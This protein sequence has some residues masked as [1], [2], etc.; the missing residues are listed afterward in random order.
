M[1]KDDFSALA[2]K[3][4]YEEEVLKHIA[5]NHYDYYQPFHLI[6]TKNG[7]T[8]TRHIDNPGKKTA[9]GQLQKKLNKRLLLP[10]VNRLPPEMVGSIKG[11]NLFS[12]LLPHVNQPTVICM[13][14]SNC[15][16]HISNKRLYNVWQRQLG[17]SEELASLLNGLTTFRGYL[18]QGPATSPLLC[19][20]ALAG[21]ASELASLCS[22]NGLVYT[23]YV[24]DICIS[25]DD[26]VARAVIGE[27]CKIARAYSQYINPRK[28]DIWDRKHQQRSAG[29]VLNQSPKLI[30]SYSNG[31]IKEIRSFEDV[32]NVTAGEKLHIMGEI[33]YIQ[34]FSKQEAQTI[35]MIFN[36][37]LRNVVEVEG[38]RTKPGI[39]KR[40]YHHDKNRY[41]NK[42]C[43]YLLPQ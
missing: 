5:A 41:N 24:D 13:D 4:G 14:L 15:F 26:N 27:V 11:K 16:P 6:I 38:K 18:P 17:F 35:K 33:L 31:V 19:N 23:Q 43:K 40:C 28:T 21:M 29:V 37:A 42:P 8:K 25:G 1:Y 32:G 22:A 2:A 7:K 9:L 34:K 36:E 10:E 20:F 12:H 3:L 30:K 39:I